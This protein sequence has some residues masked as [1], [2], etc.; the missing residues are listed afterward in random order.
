MLLYRRRDISLIIYVGS[1]FAFA[2]RPPPK[3]LAKFSSGDLASSNKN[4]IGVCGLLLYSLNS[5]NNRKLLEKLY[6][7][8]R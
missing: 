1:S 5:K 7:D 6:K 3:L 4:N 2:C 8:P